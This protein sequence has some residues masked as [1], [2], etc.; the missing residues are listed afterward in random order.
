MQPLKDLEEVKTMLKW[1]KPCKQTNLAALGMIYALE[2]QIR[3]WEIKEENNQHYKKFMGEALRINCTLTPESERAMEAYTL[4]LLQQ[5]S[6]P[7]NISEQL[8]EYDDQVSR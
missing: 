5:Q 3:Q 8:K 1:A 2:W 6:L 4:S 7:I